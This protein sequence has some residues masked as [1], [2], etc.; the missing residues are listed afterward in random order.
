M[1]DALA[2]ALHDRLLDER[3]IVHSGRG[4]QCVAMWDTRRLHGVRASPSVARVGDG[5]HPALAVPI[6]GLLPTDASHRRGRWKGIADV[7]YAP[8]QWVAWFN[9]QRLLIPSGTIAPAAFDAPYAQSRRLPR[10]PVGVNDPSLLEPRDGSRRYT[11]GRSRI[12]CGSMRESRG[13]TSRVLGWVS[14]IVPGAIVSELP[15]ATTIVPA[16]DTRA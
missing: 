10:K 13:I 14:T 11:T 12:P 3:V 6:M 2:H 5:N 4:A 16:M 15:A 9:T 1:L 8:L 7:A